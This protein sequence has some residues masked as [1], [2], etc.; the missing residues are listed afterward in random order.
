MQI[1]VL[2]VPWAR[3]SREILTTSGPHIFSSLSS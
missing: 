1:S 3:E 2:E